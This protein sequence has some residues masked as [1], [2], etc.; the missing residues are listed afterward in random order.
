MSAF[1]PPRDLTVPEPNSRTARDTLSKALGK[2]LR[3]LVSLPPGLAGAG[4][5]R[6]EAA[7]FI[8]LVRE[9]AQTN[10]GI[11][12]RL[13]REPSVGALVRVLRNLRLQGG[14]PEG[15]GLFAEL[16]ATLS[17]ELA[18]FEVL[19]RPLRLSSLPPRIVSVAL[20]R[21]VEIP[22]KTKAMVFESGRVTLEGPEG[23]EEVPFSDETPRYHPVD[24]DTLLATVDNN[25]L[26]MFEAHPDKDGNAINLGGREA[27]EWVEM[28]REC[29]QLIETFLP[30][31][32]EEI[33]L[34]V[35]Q[36]VPVG[37]HAQRHFSASYQEAI[38]T[39]YLTLHPQ[40]MTMAEAVVH[41]FSHN[42]L[43]ALFELDGVL[44][45]AFH[46]LYK[47]PVRPDPRPL[48][49]IVL[50]VHAFQPIAHMY[51]RMIAAEHPLSKSPAFHQRFE[52]I[53]AGNHEG[54][55]VVLEN[56]VPT[57]I[58]AGLLDEF[59]RWDTHFKAFPGGGEIG[60]S[61]YSHPDG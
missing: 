59:R 13:L 53:V 20:R 61:T 48:H 12:I 1:P 29:H 32:R 35:R 44:E 17:F 33:R 47:S 8:G 24:D 60:E 31:I 50:A 52:Q 14:G 16:G 5:G 34:F 39:I 15:E 27:S 36:Y 55:T 56:G 25:P 45:N 41:E 49:G 4:P 11:L 3:D 22:P 28:L 6:A 42:K 19:P 38:G 9:I 23:T 30:E 43:N 57:P 26:A 54:A 7:T 37:Y 46:P 21:V 10:P 58:G 51:E 18:A 40:L 2:G